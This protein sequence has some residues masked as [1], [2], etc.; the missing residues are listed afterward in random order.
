MPSSRT[1]TNP[2]GAERPGAP[3]GRRGTCW[4]TS[5]AG[6][7]Y[8]LACLDG[9]VAAFLGSFAERGCTDLNSVSAL[10]VAD[11]AGLSPAKVLAAWRAA[12]GQNRRRF[13]ERGGGLA[14]AP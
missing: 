13:R 7:D 14:A 8:H 3:G 12:S 11:Y 4:G 1:S 9:T 10:G 2:A 5:R 6:E